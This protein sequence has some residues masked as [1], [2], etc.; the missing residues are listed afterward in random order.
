MRVRRP[1]GRPFGRLATWCFL[2]M[3][4][5]P[6]CGGAVVRPEDAR[7]ETPRRLRQSAGVG[8]AGTV[9][10]SRRSEIADA[11]SGQ[12]TASPP[13]RANE[14]EPAPW[15][16]RSRGRGSTPRRGAG[17]VPRADT[18]RPCRRLRPSPPRP[19]PAI[20][21]RRR[22]DVFR[23]DRRTRP[24]PAGPRCRRRACGARLLG[25]AGTAPSRCLRVLPRLVARQ[26]MPFGWARR[27]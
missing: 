17:D 18:R 14:V 21:V 4:D 23:R 8:V 26:H 2:L 1:A 11:A 10:R 25:D 20:P 5:R 7:G 3:R 13:G 24:A 22:G 19:R 9:R 16:E 27:P 6:P 15:P 12:R